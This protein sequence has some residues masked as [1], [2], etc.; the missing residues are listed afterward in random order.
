MEEQWKTSLQGIL[1]IPW[2]GADK[3]E[4]IIKNY[5]AHEETNHDE[6]YHKTSKR[7]ITSRI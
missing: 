2:G 5:K 6:E 4:F 3:D 1:P 7:L